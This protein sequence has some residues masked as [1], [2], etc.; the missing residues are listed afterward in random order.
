MTAVTNSKG[1]FILVVGDVLA[2]IF[3]LILTLA[4]RYGEIPSAALLS[5]HI[6]AFSILFLVFL[7]VSFSAGLYDKQLALIHGRVQG[8]IIR[9]QIVNALIGV[10]FFYFAPVLIAPKANLFI[11]F[12]ISTVMLLLWRLV[13]FPVVSVTRKQNA[14]IIGSGPDIMDLYEEIHENAR[15][16]LTFKKHI[17]PASSVHETVAATAAAV[18]DCRASIIVAD[19]HD[20][21]VE[22]AMPY[23]YSLI[24]SGSQI[25]DA[26]KLYEAIFDRIPVSMVGERWLVENSGTALGNRSVYDGLKRLTDIVI[27]VAGGLVS[28]LF[29]LPVMAAIKLDDRG[30]IFITQ[31]RIGKNGKLLKIIKFRSMSGNDQGKYGHSG[32]TKH[33]ITRVGRFIRNTRIDEL[34]QFWNVLRGDLSMV[35]PR[36]EL[37]ALVN[38]YEKEVP[39]YNARHL[40]KP[41]LCGWAQIYHENHPHHSVDSNEARNKLYYDLYYIKNRSFMLD[42]KIILRTMQI[43]MKRVG[44]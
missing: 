32:Q 2:Y 35:G 3:S 40:V 20:P 9:V 12:I 36:P 4:V 5:I 41:G 19:L 14:L 6:A 18:R 25:I 30:P 33:T 27:A 24:F 21:A 1:M 26:S 17:V 23:L 29:Y 37:P 16:G 10:I 11:Y 34:P 43:L 13:M 39:F 7:L 42:L 8:L 22:S 31:D 28:L 38:V 15:Y 44:K